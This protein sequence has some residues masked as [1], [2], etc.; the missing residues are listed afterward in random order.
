MSY[1][2]LLKHRCTLLEMHEVLVGGLAGANWVE[3]STDVRCFI[4]LNFIRRGRDPVWTSESG[5]P[6]ERHGVL[7]LH[8]SVNGIVKSGMRV[9]MTLGPSGVFQIE[10][11]VDQAWTPRRLHHLEC[12][13]EEVGSPLAQGKVS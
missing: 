6:S 13:V 9:K 8:P 1:R 7:F 10:G 12:G 4:D 3:V 11:A 2:S 5:R